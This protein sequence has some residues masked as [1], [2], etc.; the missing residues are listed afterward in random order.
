MCLTESSAQRAATTLA[1]RRRSARPR[2][3]HGAERGHDVH[4]HD[5][6]AQTAESSLYVGS[7]DWELSANWC[8]ST[9]TSESIHV[10]LVSILLY[11]PRH[12]QFNNADRSHRTCS[13]PRTTL[14][15]KKK[16]FASNPRPCLVFSSW[17]KR[18]RDT[19][20]LL[21]VCGNFCPIIA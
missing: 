14:H 18:F 13:C 11:R 8:I 3:S 17:T 12:Q 21:F 20:A 4:A 19:V 2:R 15:I 16:N 1:E 5:V 10:W 7:G 6:T 9:W